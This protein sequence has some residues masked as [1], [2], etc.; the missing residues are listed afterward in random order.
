MD[1]TTLLPEH[2]KQI[3][4]SCYELCGG[5]CVIFRDA[6]KIYTD[7]QEKKKA[8][9]TALNDPELIF[10]Q[11]AEISAELNDVN[12]KLKGVTV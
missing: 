10:T 6:E 8:L 2:K 12:L 1:I 5:H 11:F 7:L 4:A 9:E 3:C